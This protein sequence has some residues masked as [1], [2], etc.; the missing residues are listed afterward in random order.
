MKI[1]KILKTITL[2]TLISILSAC[3]TT[4]KH[5]GM[6]PQTLFPYRKHDMTVSVSV[7][8]G[9]D[10]DAMGRTW[11]SNEEFKKAIEETI[12]RSGVFKGIV[13]GIG[14]EYQLDAMIFSIEQPIVGFSMTVKMEVGWT[15]KNLTTGMD[16]WK[17]PIKSEQ[18]LSVGDAFVGATRL[19]LA[20]EGAARNNIFQSISKISSLDLK[21]PTKQNQQ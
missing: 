12:L 19:R 1:L 2:L 11:V 4:A 15:L 6:V 17:E 10:L 14:S 16:V 20:T 5:E 13:S 3:A 7:S 21:Q 8:G 9:Q 18:T